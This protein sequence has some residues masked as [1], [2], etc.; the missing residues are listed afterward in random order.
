MTAK[1]EAEQ[2][3]DSDPELS[4]PENRLLRNMVQTDFP[5]VLDF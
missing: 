3:L 5:G 4:R 1:K 2:V